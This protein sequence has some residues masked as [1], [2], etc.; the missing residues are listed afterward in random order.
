MRRMP[1]STGPHMHT[2]CRRRNSLPASYLLLFFRR[3]PRAAIVVTPRY[4]KAASRC[5][6]CDMVQPNGRLTQQSGQDDEP[7][8]IP[9]H[10]IPFH[11][12]SSHP[13]SSN[14]R[15]R[16]EVPGVP[17]HTHPDLDENNTQ[18][19]KHVCGFQKYRCRH[20]SAILS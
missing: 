13:I 17:K 16:S 5:T 4:N 15:I 14:P 8:P 6:S 10:S 7:S 1:P 12:I 19:T 18:N 2:S 3:C 9:S 11:P 20:H